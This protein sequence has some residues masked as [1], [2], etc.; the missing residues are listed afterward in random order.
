MPLDTLS[1]EVTAKS[2]TAND[3]WN[4]P[5]GI[6]E[7]VPHSV[8]TLCLQIEHSAAQFCFYYYPYRTI[9]KWTYTIREIESLDIYV[10]GDRISISGR[11]LRRL[12]EAL[13]TGQLRLIQLAFVPIT[14]GDIAIHAIGFAD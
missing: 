6:I 3:E 14:E 2:A 1:K 13:N 4:G 7:P 12:S 8:E 11:G 5:W 9:G 10:G